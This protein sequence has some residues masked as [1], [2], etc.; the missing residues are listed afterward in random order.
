MSLAPIVL[1]VY[2]RLR[3]TQQTIDAL[4]GNYLAPESELFIFSDSHKDETVKADVERVR[5]YLKTIEGFKKITIFESEKNQGPSMLIVTGVTEI[6]NRYGKVIVLEDDLLVSRYFLKFMNDAL[7]FYEKEEKVISIC[8]Y[9][10]KV[11][12]NNQ[13]TFFLKM[14]DCWGWAT[15]KRGWD[16][17]ESNATELLERL[18]VRRMIRSFDL[19]GGYAYSK[20]LK[21][22]VEG[23]I[24]SWAIRWY[25]SAFLNNKLSLYPA[26]SLVRNVGLD[27]SGTH[28]SDIVGYFTDIFQG[29]IAVSV[30]PVEENKLAL[31]K[32]EMFLRINQF[33]KLGYSICKILDRRLKSKGG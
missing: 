13:E 20:M 16:L 25:A 23:K 21:K 17:F 22:Q 19:N 9:M 30:I 11:D 15:W 10:Y 24:S 8:G 27:G 6:I 33:K 4:R 31:K 1:F 12:I 29:E 26:Q 5:S 32:I 28:C 7:A 2:N 18:N 3:H 14:A